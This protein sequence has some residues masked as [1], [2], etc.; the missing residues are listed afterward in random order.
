MNSFC[1]SNYNTKH[2]VCKFVSKFS[3][4]YFYLRI[5]L[6]LIIFESGRNG[7]MYSKYKFDIIFKTFADDGLRHN[8]T[9]YISFYLNTFSVQINKES[10]KQKINGYV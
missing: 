8:K 9:Y 10:E 6:T 1:C 2:F 5:K 7:H 3:F 4:C